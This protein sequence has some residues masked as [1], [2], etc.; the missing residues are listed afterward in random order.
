MVYEA[1]Y[2]YFDAQYVVHSAHHVGRKYLGIFLSFSYLANISELC[3][4]ARAS[5]KVTSIS[6]LDIIRP[7]GHIDRA[8]VKL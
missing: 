5:G 1:L 4:V 6:E 8:H 2:K 7:L 3:K